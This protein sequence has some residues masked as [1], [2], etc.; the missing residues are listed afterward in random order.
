M[1][2]ALLFCLGIDSEMAEGS[3]WEAM[4]LAT[5][6]KLYNLIGIIDVNRL[7][8]RGETMYG[9]D[10]NQ[11]QK[12]ISAFGWHTI[13]IDDG[14]SL[15]KI[16][17]AYKLTLNVKDRPVMI[18]AKTIKGKGVSLMENKDGWHGKTLSADQLS[19][20]LKELGNIDKSVSGVIK[21]PQKTQFPISNFQFPNKS[22]LPRHSGG[23]AITSYQLPL[24]TRKAYGNALVRIFPKYPNIVVLD[25]ETSNSTFAEIFKKVYPERFIECFIAEQNMVGMAQG[26]TCRGKI[27]FVSSFAAFLTRAFDQIR[28]S[29][30]GNANIKFVGSHA[31]VSIGADGASQMGLED[32]AMFGT[33]LNS[34]VLYPSDAVSADK[35]VEQAAK[36]KGIVYIRTTRAH[37]PVIYNQNDIFK[38][39]GSQ[40]IK[41]SDK[42]IIT[43]IAA[44]IT[45]HQALS[46]YKELAEQNIFVRIIDCYSIKPID[47]KTLKQAASKTCQII[48][49]EDH[50]AQGGLG[51][52]VLSALSKSQTPVHIMAVRKMPRSGKPQELLDYE[53]ISKNAIIRKVKQITNL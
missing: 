29:Q 40:V 28:M 10:L 3:I 8:Q 39:G 19:Q 53:E 37:T 49:V 25:A 12:R 36:H 14:Y 15:A 7:G 48:T 23:Q 42:D 51:Q 26:L 45:L 16:I 43:I 5:Y 31:G 50:F 52:A 22:Q 33:I 24:S 6:Y 47:I 32:L 4:Q 38:V 17:K 1:I 9:H 2:I 18:I 44:G 35:L 30:Y 20:A 11:Y 46:A 27:P 13:L 41:K 34:V 21:M